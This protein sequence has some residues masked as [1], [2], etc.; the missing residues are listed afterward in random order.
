MSDYFSLLYGFLQATLNL[1]QRF[2]IQ[3]YILLF[4]NI[5]KWIDKKRLI[6]YLVI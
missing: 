1:I 3:F 6:N 4:L 5:I 2:I